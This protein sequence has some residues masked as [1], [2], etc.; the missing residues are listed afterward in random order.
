[1]AYRALFLADLH[2]SN[3]LPYARRRE[4]KSPITDRLVDTLNLL[5]EVADYA[6]ANKISTVY[7]VGD[8]LDKRLLDAVTL[9]AAKEK[10][11]DDLVDQ[12]DLKVILVPGNHEAFDAL[13]SAYTLE[14]FANL[15]PDHLKVWGPYATIEH[16]TEGLQL[17]GLPY[18]PED[19]TRET[20]RV[21]DNREGT[22]L[23]LHQSLAGGR[24]GD[25][26]CPEGITEEDL[27]GF[28]FTIAGHFH[29]QQV[30]P[31]EAAMYLG[32]P[33]QHNF[34]DAGQERGFWDVVFGKRVRA[35]FVESNAP[36]FHTLKVGAGDD[37]DAATSGIQYVR[38]NDYV[39]LDVVGTAN[40]LKD[41]LPAAA[42]WCQQLQKTTGTRLAK[43]RPLLIAE[44]K[45]RLQLVDVESGKHI[46]TWPAV[47]EGFLDGCDIDGLERR[48]LE[49]L[50]RAALQ[51]AEMRR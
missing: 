20:L 31:S 51:E 43:V 40:Q 11:V 24:A 6:K 15:R 42:E 4:E 32:A 12:R 38:E 36:R 7:V 44:K 30:L 18:K 35:N 2:I 28:M 25:W 46:I 3:S 14:A 39:Q 10:L 9:K 49:E 48:R 8:L 21:L 27:A 1:M 19:N 13:G 47:V 37:W 5:D 33:V 23:L 41:S 26:V 29:T 17:A 16:I 50:A 34:G 45:T 22:V